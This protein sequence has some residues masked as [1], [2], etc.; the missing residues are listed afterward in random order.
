MPTDITNASS[1]YGLTSGSDGAFQ[2]VA[3]FKNSHA[4]ATIAKNTAAAFDAQTT[5]TV[6]AVQTMGTS[7]D[8]ATFAGIALEDVTAGKTG[9]FVVQGYCTPKYTGSAP[10]AG[11]TMTLS[12]ATA[13]SVVFAN[14]AA[15]DV[16]GDVWGKALGG[17]IGSTGTA[18][19]WLF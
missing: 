9:R 11:H 17:Q 19:A 18:A 12:G 4:S 6:P 2:I 16:V 10:T 1:A 14:G 5:D 7:G 8:A 3:V 13:G 15:T